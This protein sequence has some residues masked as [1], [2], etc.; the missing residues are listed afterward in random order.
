MSGEHVFLVRIGPKSWAGRRS[1]K[2]LF[3]PVDWAPAHACPRL[4]QGAGGRKDH[5]CKA[6]VFAPDRAQEL[7]GQAVQKRLFFPSGLGPCARLP[8]AG[9]ATLKPS[10]SPAA[11]A[12]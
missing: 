10:L 11:L 5:V 2:R 8:V 1:K 7:G 9:T 6:C 4:L 3:S 12:Q